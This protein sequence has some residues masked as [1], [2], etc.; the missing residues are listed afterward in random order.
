MYKR[1]ARPLFFLMDPEKVHDSAIIVGRIWG[2][3]PLTKGILC[4]FFNYNNRMLEQKIDGINYRNPVGLAAGFDKDCRLMNVLHC[5][6]FGHEEVGSVT[7]EPYAGNQGKRLLRLPKDNGI[8]VYYGLKNEG[9]EVCKK[10]LKGKFKIP[11]GV[12]VAKTNKPFKSEKEKYGDW[13]KGINMMKNCGDYIT[14]NLSCPNTSDSTNHCDPKEVEKLFSAIKQAKIKFNK[15]VYLKLGWNLTSKHVDGIIRASDKAG[16]VKGFILTNLHKDR[17]KLKLKT[18][19]S[20]WN[21]QPGGISGPVVKPKAMRLVREFY[22]KAGDRY[23]IVGCGGIFSAEDAYEYIKN[24]ASL[25][26][27][28]TGMI[29]EGPYMIKSINKGLVRLLKHDGYKS[30]QEAVGSSVK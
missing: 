16:F 23:T 18:P 1:L 30:L 6:S 27:L 15:P 25:V 5:M 10:R 14:L 12:S 3:N 28:I 24:G 7:A 20:V 8:V 13:V 22:K 19:K 29:F 11:I 21:N 9:A 26:Q 17:S 4:L 2:S